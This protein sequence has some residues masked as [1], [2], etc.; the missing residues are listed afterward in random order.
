M[1]AAQ[2]KIAI[3]GFRGFLVRDA[4]ASSGIVTWML[5]QV[6]IHLLAWHNDGMGISAI[7]ADLTFV[8]S[9][10]FRKKKKYHGAGKKNHTDDSEMEEAKKFHRI[11]SMNL[12]DSSISSGHRQGVFMLFRVTE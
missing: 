1:I 9:G 11:Q 4:L 2:P 8:Y 5:N 10:R 7:V 3:L 6:F 12:L